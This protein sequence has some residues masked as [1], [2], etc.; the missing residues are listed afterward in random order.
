MKKNGSII[1]YMSSKRLKLLFLSWEKSIGKEK[2]GGAI[3][4]QRKLKEGTIQDSSSRMW[5][6]LNSTTKE[7]DILTLLIN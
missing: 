3:G 7:Y 2:G 1:N 5:R 6:K 4:S